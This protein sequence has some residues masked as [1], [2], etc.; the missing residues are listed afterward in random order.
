MD[1]DPAFAIF[2]EIKHWFDT[3]QAINNVIIG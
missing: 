1:M 2:T 3:E